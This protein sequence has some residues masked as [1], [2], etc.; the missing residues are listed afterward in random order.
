MDK[1]G[2]TKEELLAKINEYAYELKSLKETAKLNE[3]GTSQLRAMLEH[4]KNRKP[5]IDKPVMP[6]IAITG[7]HLDITLSFDGD[8]LTIDGGDANF[9]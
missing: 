8:T 5:F 3:T 9:D 7:H 2:M 1:I 4:E 6:K